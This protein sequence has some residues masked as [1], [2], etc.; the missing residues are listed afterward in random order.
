MASC[1]RQ[2]SRSGVFG[3]LG[4]KWTRK[5]SRRSE[6]LSVPATGPSDGES[7]SRAW[8]GIYPGRMTLTAERTFPISDSAREAARLGLEG[9]ET[10][11]GGMRWD[12]SD[13]VGTPL[14]AVIEPPVGFTKHTE[15]QWKQL[16]GGLVA[17]MLA[18][19]DSA[20]C[21]AAHV[22][23]AGLRRKLVDVEWHFDDHVGEVAAQ[24]LELP[25]GR[26]ALGVGL[27][28]D[29]PLLHWIFDADTTREAVRAMFAHAIEHGEWPHLSRD[30]VVE[31]LQKIT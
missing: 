28:H 3:A 21:I 17:V 1:A 14:D 20:G 2:E 16:C 27:T 10:E 23:A 24:I 25:D 29:G 5:A 13:W 8:A 18:G 6:R 7:A 11:F 15:D 22:V 19:C 4:G 9:A 31:Q 30:Q 26:P 12:Q